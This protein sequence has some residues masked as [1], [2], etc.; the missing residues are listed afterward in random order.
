MKKNLVWIDLEMTGLCPKKHKILEIAVSITDSNLNILTKELVINI[1]QCSKELKK[2]NEW[3]K[4]THNKTGL[5]KKVKKSKYDEKK[6]E[7][8][9]I[10]FLK[11]WIKKNQSPLCGNTIWKDRQFLKKYMPNLESY[12]HYRN[13]DISTIKELYHRWK[14]N[15]WKNYNKKNNHSALQDI[16]DSIKEL[17]FYK[18]NFFIK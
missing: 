17:L 18:K 4:K 14:K 8:I 7:K 13:I 15:H 10:N 6:A 12:F 3:N 1:H 11:K 2:M 9:I 5:I 16:R